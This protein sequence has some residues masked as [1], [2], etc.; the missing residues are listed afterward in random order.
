[1]K[2][3]VFF[4]N[5]YLYG[6]N[7]NKTKG[8]FETKNSKLIFNQTT[9][10]MDY[11]TNYEQIPQKNNGQQLS[12]SFTQVSQT[13]LGDNEDENFDLG[14]IFAVIRRR[15]L[16]MAGIGLTLSALGGALIVKS[17]RKVVPVYQ[18]SFQLLVE[19]IT[20]EGRLSRLFLMAQNI[21]ANADIQKIKIEDNSLIDYETLIRVLRSPTILEPI[22]DRLKNK[23]PDINYNRLRSGIEITRI[24]VDKGIEEQGT[25]ILVIDYKS[26]D[27]KKIKIVLEY[28]EKAYLEYSLEERLTNLRQGI[29]F[30]KKKLPNLRQRVDVL[31]GQVQKLRQNYNVFDPTAAEQLLFAQSLS[32]QREQ[33]TLK[34]QLAQTRSLYNH[35]QQQLENGKIIAVLSVENQS[36]VFLI[37]QIQQLESELAAQSTLFLD[38]SEPMQM[39]RE[40]QKSLNALGYRE[41]GS[42]LKKISGK[43]EEQEAKE[44]TLAENITKRN[45]QL[46]QLPVVARQ[47]ADLERELDVATNTLKEFLSKLEALEVDA[48]RQ[49]IPWQVIQAPQLRKDSGGNLIPTESTQTKSQLAVIVVVCTLLGVGVGFLIEVLITVFHTPEEVKAATKIPVLGMIPVAKELK[50]PL[51]GKRKKVSVLK[52]MD[53]NGNHFVERDPLELIYSNTNLLEA[54][55][56][57]YTNIRLLSYDKSLQSLVITSS[58]SGDGKST[59]AVNLAQIAATVGQKVLLVDAD[60]RDPQIHLHLNLPNLHGFS[61]ALSTDLSLNDAIQRSPVNDNLFVLTAGEVPPD[62]IKLLSSKKKQYLMEQF[63][64][65]F[66]LVIYDTPSLVNLADANLIAAHADGTIVVVAIEKTDR[67]M[68][69]KGL[70][71]FKISGGSPLGTVTNFIKS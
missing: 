36:Y 17:A 69:T 12:P 67:S 60:L 34:G 28:L 6:S 19:P 49:E 58:T 56:S 48:A 65:F 45:E 51:K 62:P 43:I 21:D 57:F 59:V 7:N 15:L 40:K 32:L 31:Q 13:N 22:V 71:G 53:R 4:N 63:Q 26:K 42:I 27:T 55:R 2:Y 9:L 20:A 29:N 16:I 25:K 64:A 11:E 3:L 24:S 10:D 14:W 68:L 54:F 33:L 70:E 38:N 66:D 52:A 47:Y 46:R 8:D 37:R 1:M 39:L 5:K 18:G 30:I 41:A 50:K 35:L 44:R 61:D 23:Y